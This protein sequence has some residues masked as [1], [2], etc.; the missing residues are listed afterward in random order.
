MFW[1]DWFLYLN[2]QVSGQIHQIMSLPAYIKPFTLLPSENAWKNTLET[3]ENA[4]NDSLYTT[5]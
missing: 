3:Y 4:D 5:D 1:S 2:T